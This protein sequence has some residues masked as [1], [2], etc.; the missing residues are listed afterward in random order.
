MNEKFQVNEYWL[1]RGETY[2]HEPRLSTG[3]IDRLI[4][5]ALK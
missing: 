2:I 3:Y 4:A 5:F 1:R